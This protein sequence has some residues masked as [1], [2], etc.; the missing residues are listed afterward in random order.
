MNNKEI[1]DKMALSPMNVVDFL[2][3]YISRVLSDSGLMMVFEDFFRI[4]TKDAYKD[5]RDTFIGFTINDTKPHR[6]PPATPRP[7]ARRSTSGGSPRT[8]AGPR[9]RRTPPSP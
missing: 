6:R 8:E 1:L 3:E 4:Q 7:S 2:Y 9:S 5:V